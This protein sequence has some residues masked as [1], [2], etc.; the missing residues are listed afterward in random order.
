VGRKLQVSS[1]IDE[2]AV[3]ACIA[4]DDLNPIRAKM[5]TTSETSKHTSIQQRIHALIKGDQPRKLTRFVGN[6]RQYI[7][8]D[9]AYSLID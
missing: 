4:Y 5:D 6:N 3:L 9:I 1:F 7:P 8:K 2:S